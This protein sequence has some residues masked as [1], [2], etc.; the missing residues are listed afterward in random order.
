MGETWCY[1]LPLALRAPRDGSGVE[2]LQRAEAAREGFRGVCR[3]ENGTVSARVESRL[4]SFI[5]KVKQRLH[6]T[7]GGWALAGWAVAA[8]AR[9]DQVE[10]EVERLRAEEEVLE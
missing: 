5:R 7:L 8:P 10:S 2:F 1:H 3:D 9:A 4:S 6:Y